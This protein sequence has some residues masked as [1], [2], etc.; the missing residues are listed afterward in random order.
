MNSLHKKILRISTR[1]NYDLSTGKKIKKNSFRLYPKKSF[2]K[3]NG[4]KELVIMIH[5]L[6][7]D[8]KGAIDKI[9]LAK[10]R[11]QQL[12]YV[13]PVIGFSYDSNTKG[14]HIKKSQVKA[15]RVGQKIAKQNGQNLSEFIIYFKKKN[16][17]TK[18]RLIGHSLGTEVILSTIKKLASS[19]KNKNIIESV[20]FFGSSLENDFAQSKKSGKIL[21]KIIKNKILNYYC[22]T[23]EVLKQSQQEGLIKNPLGYLG[24][25]KKPIK[26]F[27]QK[28]ILAKNHRFASYSMMLKSFP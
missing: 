22:P 4:T 21:Q 20:Y 26:K 17:I 9:I 10:R 5:G 25:T 3:L 28:K 13:Y 16:P 1:G 2:D 18:I 23:D 14:A 12:G 27:I 11:L 8:R 6:R 24:H 15:L 19:P 7:N